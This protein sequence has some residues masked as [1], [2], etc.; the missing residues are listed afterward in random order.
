[1]NIILFLVF[2]LVVGLLARAIMPGTQK[3][4]WIGTMVLGVVGSF[5]G[6]FIAALLTHT[7]VLDFNTSGLIGSIVGA[8]IAL[9]LGG[10]AFS[11]GRAT[12]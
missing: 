6:G 8:L 9:A 5:I 7:Q 1:M 4:G 10:G 12:I 11:R 3:M 2:G